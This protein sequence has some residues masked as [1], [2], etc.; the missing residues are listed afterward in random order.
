M[1][2][3]SK[4]LDNKV[5]PKDML[6]H[7]YRARD[8][9]VQN[10]WQRSIFIIPIILLILTAYGVLWG[11]VLKPSNN[12]SLEVINAVTQFYGISQKSINYKSFQDPNFPNISQWMHI[13]FLAI[14][15]FGLIFSAL[16]VFLS[17]ASKKAYEQ[18]EDSIIECYENDRLKRIIF[19]TLVFIL[20]YF[21]VMES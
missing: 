8:I 3:Y 12:V 19:L 18:V 4:K 9:E 14:S 13:A 15:L 21:L 20:I 1:V 5:T 17:R 16:W 10:H 11:F 2:S 6:E 7:L